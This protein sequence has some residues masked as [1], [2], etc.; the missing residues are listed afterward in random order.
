MLLARTPRHGRMLS[1]GQSKE[2]DFTAD[3]ASRLLNANIA[4]KIKALD[5]AQ[6]QLF[7]QDLIDTKGFGMDMLKFTEGHLDAYVAVSKMP[8]AIRQEFFTLETVALHITERGKSPTVIAAELTASGTYDKWLADH[9]V[10]YKKNGFTVN[11]TMLDDAFNIHMD[12]VESVTS[13]KSNLAGGV[14]GGHKEAEFMTT[15]SDPSF[16]NGKRVVIHGT[17]QA[18][19]PGWEIIEYKTIA[20]KSGNILDI[21]NGVPKYNGDANGNPYIAKKSVYSVTPD[22]VKRLG[23]RIF[24]EGIDDPSKI[25]GKKDKATIDKVSCIGYYDQNNIIKTWYPE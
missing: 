5:P 15:V 11:K 20:E 22:E 3:P 1:A 2:W 9:L 4:T 24:K 7:L 21:T 8:V 12:K 13:I 17:P 23:Y 18:S 6:K 19:L 14:S 25:T 16:S 10:T